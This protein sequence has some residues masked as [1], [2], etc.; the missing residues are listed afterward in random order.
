MS[1]IVSGNPVET[2]PNHPRDS[3][4]K[5]EVAP[6][7]RWSYQMYD[8]EVAGI[9]NSKPFTIVLAMTGSLIVDRQPKP[10]TLFTAMQNLRDWV[11]SQ[12][13][14]LAVPV[15]A[16]T[17]IVGIDPIIG[18]SSIQ[19]KTI[20]APTVAGD[21]DL[22]PN[23]VNLVF[24]VLPLGEARNNNHASQLTYGTITRL[25]E[26]AREKDYFWKDEINVTS[27]PVGG[28][29]TQ[30]QIITVTAPVW[31]E[32]PDVAYW[33]KD[34]VALT[35]L[36]DATVNLVITPA[37]LEDE[38]DYQAKGGLRVREGY[39]PAQWATTGI[40]VVTILPA[41]FLVT[42]T[43]EEN[44]VDEEGELLITEDS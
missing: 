43:G 2:K 10:Q 39:A 26:L 30:G 27:D 9:V 17:V 35:P 23:N 41:T 18:K 5:G 38:G 15:D 28:E 40:A 14:H 42:E 21:A 12:A 24:G 44:I 7:Y 29:F 11:L 8:R 33:M 3:V 19:F 25:M 31:G 6:N 16:L 32:V 37:A 36:Q 4:I 13:P 1:L 20:V 22:Y 34:G